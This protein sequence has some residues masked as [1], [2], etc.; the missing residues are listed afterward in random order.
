MPAPQQRTGVRRNTSPLPP[1]TPA[2]P[3]P[4]VSELLVQIH[5]LRQ[6]VHQLQETVGRLTRAIQDMGPLKPSPTRVLKLRRKP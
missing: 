5:G 4:S 6:H 2:I 1:L 3:E